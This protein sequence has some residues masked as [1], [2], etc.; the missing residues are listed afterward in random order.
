MP[1]STN[2]AVLLILSSGSV[3]RAAEDDGSKIALNNHCRTC[4]SF[5]SGDNRLGP[6]MAG[7]FGAKAG[8]VR[9]Y[10]GY[11]GGLD[12]ITW[13]EA[14]PDKFI[15]NPMAVSTSTNMI[16]PPIADASERRKII[17]FLKSIRAP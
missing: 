17:E 2:L 13:D 7:V 5:K 6:S 14:T 8:Q 10:R 1:R 9:G 16:F 3:V 15:A 4:H 11:S 12:G